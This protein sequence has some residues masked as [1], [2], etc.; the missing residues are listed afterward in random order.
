M[1]GSD[2]Y[3]IPVPS[4]S[5]ATPTSPRR[6]LLDQDA[7]GAARKPHTDHTQHCPWPEI[8]RALDIGGLQR[9][10]LAHLLRGEPMV[11]AR[12]LLFDLRGNQTSRH[13]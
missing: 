11:S 12:V 10:Q 1:A 9:H 3:P 6:A 2:R 7:A 5:R 4:G 13:L 8:D